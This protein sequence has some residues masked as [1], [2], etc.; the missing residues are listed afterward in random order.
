VTL[1]DALSMTPTCFTSL[2]GRK[3]NVSCD[4]LISP[5]TVKVVPN[6]GM[7]T[8]NKTGRGCLYIKFNI[9]FPLQMDTDCQNLMV[10][11]LKSNAIE[12]EME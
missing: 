8:A 1:A 10:S 7:P 12:L 11:A 9:V 2:D 3:M 6:E 4:E 5:K